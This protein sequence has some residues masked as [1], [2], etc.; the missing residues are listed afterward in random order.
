MLHRRRRYAAE[1]W[2]QGLAERRALERPRWTD[3]NLPRETIS[4]FEAMA[5]CRAR[6]RERGELTERGYGNREPAVGRRANC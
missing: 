1:T 3:P 6:L 4:W 5:F 2:W